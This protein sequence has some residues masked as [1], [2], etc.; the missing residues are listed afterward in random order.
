MAVGSMWMKPVARMTPVP[1][2]F[3]RVKTRAESRSDLNLEAMTGMNTPAVL[4][5]RMMKTLAICRP[6]LY[7]SLTVASAWH[8]SGSDSVEVVCVYVERRVSIAKYIKLLV[9]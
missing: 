8:S 7:D 4:A 5:V 6:V 2:C 3:P 1:N 9:D